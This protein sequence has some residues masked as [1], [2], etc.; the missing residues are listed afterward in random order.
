M[1]D[2]DYNSNSVDATL[3]RIET[4]LKSALDALIDQN[5][6]LGILETAENKRAGALATVGFICGA[7]GTGATLLVEYIKG[8]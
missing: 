6:R 7:I 4:N 3:A 5:R 2:G 8:R 1:S